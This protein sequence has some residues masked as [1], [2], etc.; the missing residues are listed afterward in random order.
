MDFS[1]VYTG[2]VYGAEDVLAD[3]TALE[4]RGNA[5]PWTDLEIYSPGNVHSR[6]DK[7]LSVPCPDLCLYSRM[8]NL[9]GFP[10]P[11]RRRVSYI[12]EE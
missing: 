9:E 12:Q 6:K 4:A 3:Q 10:S 1:A 8:V 2:C 11:S 5:F 7:A